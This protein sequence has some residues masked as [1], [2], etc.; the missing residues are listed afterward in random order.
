LRLLAA[1]DDLDVTRLLV[2]LHLRGLIVKVLQVAE[3]AQNLHLAAHLQLQ[4]LDF[5]MVVGEGPAWHLEKGRGRCPLGDGASS[6]C[7]GNYHFYL[8]IITTNNS[9]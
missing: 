1:L 3:H 2:I 4:L 6:K 9:K 8:I 5:P 7:G